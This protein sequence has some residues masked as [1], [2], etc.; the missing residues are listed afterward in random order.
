MTM[1]KIDVAA[2]GRRFG[3]RKSEM[4]KS[5][6]E[7]LEGG[8]PPHVEVLDKPF[9][10][11]LPGAKMLVSQPCE[12]DVFIRELPLGTMMSIGDLRS[13]IAKRHG[14]DVACPISTS[15]FVRISAEAALDAV[16]AGIPI[17]SVTP[18]WRVIDPASPLAKKLSCGA[19]VIIEQRAKEAA[20]R[21]N[22]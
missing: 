21:G 19:A 2:I 18:F 7:K 10:G 6:Q 8:K 14:A 20:V 12:V 17:E 5:W 3:N 22:K 15:I 9:G 1:N 4:G 13:S 16:A 11:A